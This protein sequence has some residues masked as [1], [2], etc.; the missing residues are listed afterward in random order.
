MEFISIA[1]GLFQPLI[2]A[3]LLRPL[4]LD[5]YSGEAGQVRRGPIAYSLPRFNRV[6]V[7]LK[8]TGKL[9]LSGAAFSL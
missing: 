8:N 3:L 9:Q 4:T 1:A 5:M 7:A 6:S 2:K